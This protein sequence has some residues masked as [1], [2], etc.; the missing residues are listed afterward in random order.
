MTLLDKALLFAVKAHEG[1]YRKSSS[2]PYAVHVVEVVKRV[3][4]YT[5]GENVLV[6]SVLH[7]YIEDCNK[8]GYAVL[9]KE[10]NEEV[11]D[12][13]IEC[14]RCATMS[15]PQQ[16]VEFIL[17]LGLN[18]S[19][20]ALLIKL[21]DRFSNTMDFM[22]EQEL[23]EKKKGSDYYK[24]YGGQFFPVI[25]RLV[26][27]PEKSLNSFVFNDMS[28]ILEQVAGVLNVNLSNMPLHEIHALW[29]EHYMTD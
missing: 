11:A 26:S 19:I 9:C 2:L 23:N 22:R 20:G 4:L 16:K 14:T 8:D 25:E 6:A 15:S 28:F 5:T 18:G 13:V 12:L 21:A 24:S 10:F 1:Q 27:M 3:S 29:L 17:D 7:D